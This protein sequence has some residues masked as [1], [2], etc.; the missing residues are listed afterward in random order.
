MQHLKIERRLLSSDTPHHEFVNDP[1][2][3]KLSKSHDKGIESILYNMPHKS[4]NKLKMLSLAKVNGGNLDE[5]DLE[6]IPHDE[7]D[8]ND[9]EHSFAENAFIDPN[10]G[11]N[12]L[13]LDMREAIDNRMNSDVEDGNDGGSGLGHFLR[14]TAK[15]AKHTI[16]KVHRK[17]KRAHKKVKRALDKTHITDPIKI[18]TKIHKKI[19]DTVA[20]S[21]IPVVSDAAKL[22]AMGDKAV[23]AAI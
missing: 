20:D 23:L 8:Y 19:A 11:Q 14:K 3:G 22:G 13:I 17:I 12:H 2:L 1:W 15:A 21:G 18:Y 16:K 10:Y 6:I 7:H 9:V 5:L 4:F